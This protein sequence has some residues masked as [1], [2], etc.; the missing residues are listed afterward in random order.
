MESPT[1]FNVY[2]D[3][4]VRIARH[5][6]LKRH[7][8]TGFKFKYCIPNEVSL[9]DLRGKAKA[10]GE[11]RI[12]ELLYADD[13][14]I[15]AESA[16]E[17]Q[18]ILNV[19][20]QTFTR[21]G[22]QMSYSKT[23]TM[24]FNVQ[25]DVNNRDTLLQLNNINIK[26]IRSFRYLGYTVTNTN[27]NTKS[28]GLRIGSAFEKW[29]ELKHVL[30]DHHIKMSTRAKFLNA[31]VR[32][33]L[34]S[35]QI[36]PLSEKEQSKIESVWHG[37]LRRMVKGGYKRMKDD[38]NEEVNDEEGW[39]F[40]Y[41][42]EVLW[43]ITGTLTGLLCEPPQIPPKQDNMKCEGV[44]NV[45]VPKGEHSLRYQ[46]DKE[47]EESLLANTKET[48][49]EDISN[50]NIIDTV[51]EMHPTVEEMRQ[52]RVAALT[53]TST[54]DITNMPDDNLPEI[55]DLN[56]GIPDDN[57]GAVSDRPSPQLRSKN[58]RIHRSYLK[59]DLIADFK[60]ENILNRDITF[61]VINQRGDVE[62]GAG[63]GV[64]RE[65][66]S[67]FWVDFSISMTI[68]ER[69][70]V[71][72]VRHDHFVDEWK[73]VGR[74]LVKGYRSLGGTSE[75][76]INSI[77]EKPEIPEDRDELDDFLERF[78]CRTNVSKENI[79]KILVEISKQE[80]VQ[81]PH[82][83]AAA[84]QPILQKHLKVCPEFQ[85]VSKV[86]AF[87]E[88]IK[89]T[90]KKVL[91]SIECN[92]NTS[93]ERDVLKF[94]QRFIRR[95]EMPKLVQFLRFTTTMDI[96]GR[97]KLQVTFIKSEGF[98]SRPIAHTCG[99]VLELPSTYTNFVELREEFTNILNRDKW[100][101]DI[102]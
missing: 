86:E 36:W 16:E 96:M 99:L 29:N 30:T 21:F 10:R 89:P 66:Y 61:E 97:N 2:M 49:E 47:Y 41:S 17:L 91:D 18:T 53:A 7:P 25:E 67:S 31:Y 56:T 42:N 27:D 45:H 93:G 94:L 79:V 83:M 100:E 64:T 22:L 52:R 69:E 38:G 98:G 15:F 70:R 87:Y 95:L 71:P 73:A 20:D 37:F 58:L 50:N 26:N 48:C 76:M 75:E 32:S 63:I 80:L 59:K 81:K 57:G 44:I 23:E 14:A 11:N 102:V 62:Q 4:V 85:S 9:R 3:F 84:W 46:Q 72:F 77:L 68:G 19:Y 39:H 5:E 92:P 13:Q 90:T 6:I 74:I 54:A 12:T 1:L 28:L 43:R 88:G 65:V 51:E 34:L 40:K 82:L 55:P 78:N 35:V 24:A 101:M 8:E 60:D 33:R